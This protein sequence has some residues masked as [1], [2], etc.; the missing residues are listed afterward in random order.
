MLLPYIA[1]V[2][3][4]K[5]CADDRAVVVKDGEYEQIRMYKDCPDILQRLAT[6]N[7]DVS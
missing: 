2:R 5:A 6:A 1:L 7:V 4:S 3:E